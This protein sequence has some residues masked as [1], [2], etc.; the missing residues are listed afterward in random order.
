MSSLTTSF[1][2]EFEP[3][4]TVFRVQV[5]GVGELVSKNSIGAA[6]FAPVAGNPISG[7][8]EVQNNVPGAI[9]KVI[10]RSTGATL[11][12]DE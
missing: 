3:T 2:T 5:N 7:V 4:L 10:S 6:A 11:E 9:Y 8:V 12:V 1:D